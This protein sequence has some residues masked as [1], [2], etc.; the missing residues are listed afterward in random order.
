MQIFHWFIDLSIVYQSV[1]EFYSAQ[2]SKVSAN[3]GKVQFEG[4]VHI[5]KYIRYTRTLGLKYYANINDAPVSDLLR[6]ASIK[7]ENQFMGFSDSSWQDCPDT[8]I[9]IGA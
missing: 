4:L 1:L 8:V 6:Q 7:T 3:P 9:I 2:V 5:L